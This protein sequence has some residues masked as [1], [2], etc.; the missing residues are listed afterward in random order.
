MSGFDPGQQVMRQ[1]VYTAHAERDVP[2]ADEPDVEPFYERIRTMLTALGPALI[3]SGYRQDVSLNFP[4][5]A[6]APLEGM[7]AVRPSFRVRIH[8]ALLV[9]QPAAAPTWFIPAR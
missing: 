6:G 5:L 2:V 7:G 3:G 8:V 4:V 1:T 9:F